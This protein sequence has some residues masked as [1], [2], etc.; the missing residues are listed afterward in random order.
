MGSSKHFFESADYIKLH[1]QDLGNCVYEYEQF[2][3]EALP[4]KRPTAAEIAE[5]DNSGPVLFGLNQD[6]LPFTASGHST[7]APEKTSIRKIPHERTFLEY[8]HTQTSRGNI[9]I[10][11]TK[12]AT[13]RTA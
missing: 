8:L 1:L 4:I 5:Y 13:R 7:L 6:S 12:P 10:S 9:S 11:V 3:A 2:L